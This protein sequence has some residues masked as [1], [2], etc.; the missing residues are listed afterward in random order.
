MTASPLCKKDPFI[1][2]DGI[3]SK[4]RPLVRK[5]FRL[6][7]TA[8]VRHCPAMNR[9]STILKPPRAKNMGLIAVSCAP[10]DAQ[11]ADLW[12]N[13]A[14]SGFRGKNIETFHLNTRRY[15]AGITQRPCAAMKKATQKRASAP[16]KSHKWRHP[17]SLPQRM[18]DF[19]LAHAPKWNPNAMALEF[20][21]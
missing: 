8:D 14:T 17:S 15:K 4:S 21:Q 6:T 12:A 18:D 16:L 7:I 11:N 9:R 10:R 3:I 19:I 13:V 20:G 5:C 2:G 1:N